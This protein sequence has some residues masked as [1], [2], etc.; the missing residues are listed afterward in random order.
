M[1]CIPHCYQYA[2]FHSTPCT[3]CLAFPLVTSSDLV[4][5][6]A[7]S[8]LVIDY[9]VHKAKNLPS[10][11]TLCDFVSGL[12]LAFESLTRA[13]WDGMWEMNALIKTGVDTTASAF[14]CLDLHIN[15][16]DSTAPYCSI[17]TR[18]ASDFRIRPFTQPG[19]LFRAIDFSFY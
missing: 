16:M 4:C 15:P 9:E 18:F 10:G 17:R 3:L 2:L 6:F 14:R 8:G 11:R 1:S 13:E 19:L 5:R 7:S 12:I